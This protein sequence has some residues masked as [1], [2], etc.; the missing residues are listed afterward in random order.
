[1]KSLLIDYR[2]NV[3]CQNFSKDLQYSKQ[4]LILGD[5]QFLDHDN[6]IL[7]IERK[8]VDDLIQSIKDGRYREQKQRIQASNI[9]PHNCVYLIEGQIPSLPLNSKYKGLYVSAI[10]S[11][12]LKSSIRDG[13]HVFFA[14]TIKDTANIIEHLSKKFHSNESPFIMVKDS[15]ELESIGN[16]TIKTNINCEMKKKNDI[17]TKTCFIYQLCQIPGISEKIAVSLSSHAASITEFIDV[18]RSKEDVLN[19]LSSL[20]VSDKR[21]IGK[22][23]AEKILSYLGISSNLSTKKKS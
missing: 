6:L 16:Q 14:N 22:K 2:E 10:W 1:M 9:H 20:Q 12:I 23:T 13:F 21:K 15:L 11:A 3:L 17:T 19:W 4:N 8:T 18:V 5:I 7:L